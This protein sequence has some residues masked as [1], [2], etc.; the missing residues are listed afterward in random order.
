MDLDETDLRILDE[1][2]RD[3]RASMSAVAQ[4]VHISRAGAYARVNRL[5]EAGVITGFSARVD[6]VRAGLHSSAYVTLS[7]DQAPWQ[8][9]RAQLIQIP[10]VKHIALVGGEVDLL[11]LVRARDNHDL[12]RVVLEQLQSIPSVRSTK[13]WLIFEDFDPVDER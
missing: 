3:G 10:E 8:D 13:T 7:V 11:L 4:A 12:R 6:P 9:L 1:L 5:T 2:Q